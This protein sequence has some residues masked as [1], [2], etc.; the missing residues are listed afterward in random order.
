MNTIPHHHRWSAEGSAQQHWQ[1]KVVEDQNSFFFSFLFF[2]VGAGGGGGGH[3]GHLVFYLINW[4]Q[5]RCVYA[6]KMHAGLS[7][8]GSK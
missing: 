7:Q 6:V 1:E 8:S 5:G 2:G 4:F 3:V